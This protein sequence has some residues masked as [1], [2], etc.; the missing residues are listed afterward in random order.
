MEDD[1]IPGDRTE[2]IMPDVI[3]NNIQPNY[4]VHEDTTLDKTNVTQSQKEISKPKKS[5]A[6]TK[7]NE[8]ISEG[9]MEVIESSTTI[10]S[11][12]SSSSYSSDDESVTDRMAKVE[13]KD[14]KV[15]SLKKKG[16][17]RD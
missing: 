15:K 7:E 9:P 1:Q 2:E 6:D 17:R 13:I 4:N 3:E 10:S 12:F 16:A 5:L 11:E 8:K 14:K